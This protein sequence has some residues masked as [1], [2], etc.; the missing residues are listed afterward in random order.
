MTSIKCPNC[1]A[2]SPPGAIFCDNCGYDLRNAPLNA[3][4]PLSPTIVSAEAGGLACNNC[5]HLNPREAIYCENCGTKIP[6]QPD[7]V[8]HIPRQEPSPPARKEIVGRL[9]IQSTN[10]NLPFP[11][12]KSQITL[13]R[14]DPVSGIFP[15]IDL[16]PYGAQEAGVGRQH[17]K[18]TIQ[19][20][21]MYIE[22]LNSVN[23]TLVN[24]KRIQPGQPVMLKNGDEIRLGLLIINFYSN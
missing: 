24:K 17:A 22:D 4:Q 3:P 10:A 21:A 2:E 23:G 13:G 9:V 8:T 20:Q 7:A 1:E 14:E 16:T 11:A 5:G 12:G 15:D 19:N 18:M 6:Q